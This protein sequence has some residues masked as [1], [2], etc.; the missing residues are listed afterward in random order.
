MQLGMEP[1]KWLTRLAATDAV[2]GTVVTEWQF[3][4][5][6]ARPWFPA[7]ASGRRI[8]GYLCWEALGT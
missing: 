6:G 3:A 4:C 5:P 8:L 1:P 2:A 7:L